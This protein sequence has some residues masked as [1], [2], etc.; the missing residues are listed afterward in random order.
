MIFL[1]FTQTLP[2]YADK[3]FIAQFASSNYHTI[4]EDI[5]GVSK[6]YVSTITGIGSDEV[7]L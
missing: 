1:T 3:S 4:N 5:I 6:P 2:I 7:R